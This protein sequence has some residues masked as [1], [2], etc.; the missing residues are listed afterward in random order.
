MKQT[1]ESITIKKRVGIIKRALKTAG[2]DEHFIYKI[3]KFKEKKKTFEMVSFDD[4]KK[5]RKTA[6]GLSDKKTIWL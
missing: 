1:C 4:L 5:L 3:N 6:L 2:I